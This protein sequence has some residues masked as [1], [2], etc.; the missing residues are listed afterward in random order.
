MSP[1]FYDFELIG[2]LPCSTWSYPHGARDLPRAIPTGMPFFQHATHMMR[3]DRQGLEC[4]EPFDR[5]IICKLQAESRQL[6]LRTVESTHPDVHAAP[7]VGFTLSTEDPVIALTRRDETRDRFDPRLFMRSLPRSHGRSFRAFSKDRGITR[8]DLCDPSTGN[9]P[10]QPVKGL[11]IIAN[12]S[13]T[14]S[15]ESRSAWGDFSS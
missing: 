13:I 12:Q 8:K 7:H 10:V 11:L 6:L 4:D 1:S 15:P 9:L 5:K 14:R 2:S 3:I